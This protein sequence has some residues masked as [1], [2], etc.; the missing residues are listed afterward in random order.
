MAD[1]IAYRDLR[2]GEVIQAGDEWRQMEG[3]RAC[4]LAYHSDMI[5]K[6]LSEFCHGK[7]RRPYNIT[8]LLRQR[9]QAGHEYRL[10]C[11]ALT[12]EQVAHK[13]TMV[14]GLQACK[15]RDEAEQALQMARASLEETRAA[16]AV[17]IEERNE[18]ERLFTQARA[19]QDRIIGERDEWRRQFAAERS[20][21]EV[22]IAERN[23]AH[24][25]LSEERE[26]HQITAKERDE[27]QQQRQHL[28][29]ALEE[30]QRRRD[31]AAGVDAL[32]VGDVVENILSALEIA[33]HALEYLADVGAN[34]EAGHYCGFSAAV[35][36]VRKIKEST[37]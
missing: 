19:A 13:A 22:A 20:A 3:G 23:E 15:E 7:A 26:L 10:A 25:W 28:Q 4:W 8:E 17:V 16:R 34:E 29:T 24:Q 31:V 14:N 35:A 12:C 11:E 6:T 37:K 9:D 1:E 21:R 33:G 27:C 18:A 36:V 30:L 2:P 5:G 32:T